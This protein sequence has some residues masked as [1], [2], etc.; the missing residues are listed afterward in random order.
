ME[1]IRTVRREAQAL[2]R[3]HEATTF[4]QPLPILASVFWPTLLFVWIYFV[5]ISSLR[6]YNWPLAVLPGPALGVVVCT[7]VS[8]RARKQ[9]KATEPARGLVSLAI[10]LW[11]ALAL[12]CLQ[13]ELNYIWY[14]TNYYNYQDLASYTDINPLTDRGQSFMDAGQVYFREGTYVAREE[15]TAYR[16]TNLYCAAPIVGLPI[17]NQVMNEQLP[18][19]WGS[20]QAPSPIE[21]GAGTPSFRMPDS[22]T[23]DFWAV[24]MD[25]CNQ[26][27]GHFNCGQVG[28]PHARAGMR[29][30]RDDSRPFYMLAVQA[31]A[32]KLCPENENTIQGVRAHAPLICLPA[33][34]PLFF[35]WV[36]DPIMEVDTF[37][38]ES[39]T[40]FGMHSVLFVAMDLFLTLLILAFLFS[41]GVR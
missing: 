31:W 40:L 19:S 6:F 5:I 10:C 36:T 9:L 35:Y 13:G 8:L 28:S 7:A 17:R 12:G 41:I 14:V 37:I 15:M 30:L 27:T 24:G 25:C 18:F 21:H 16:S 34:H 33:K 3:K 39:S 23:I 1:A 2:L 29:M 26:T 38:A 32:A 22:G 4:L 11:L 20:Y